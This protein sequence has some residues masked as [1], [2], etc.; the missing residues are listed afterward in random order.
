M[1]ISMA[2]S[3]P[4]GS[5]L[6]TIEKDPVNHAAAVQILTKALTASAL[7]VVAPASGTIRPPSSADVRSEQSRATVESWLGA[8]GDVLESSAFRQRHGRN[9]PFNLVLMD[10]WK[11]EVIVG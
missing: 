3:L 11:P 1:A 7:D 10:H 4:V 2:L 6:V 5:L 8:S 9:K